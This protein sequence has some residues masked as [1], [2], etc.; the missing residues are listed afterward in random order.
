[1]ALFLVAVLNAMQAVRTSPSTGFDLGGALWSVAYPGELG[2]WVQLAGIVA[3]ALVGGM[4]IAAMRARRTRG[5]T[6]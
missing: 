6:E 5:A 2:G 1:V 4:F 3:F